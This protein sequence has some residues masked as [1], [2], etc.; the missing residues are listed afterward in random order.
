MLAGR[1][2]FRSYGSEQGLTNL[3]I[4]SLE[5]D[6]D[7]FLWVGTESGL[8]RYD[9]NRFQRFSTQDG[10]PADLVRVVYASRSGPLWLGTLQGVAVKEGNRIQALGTRS[11]LNA[12]EVFTFAEEPDG[13]IWIGADH[14][15]FRQK[16]GRLQFEP[17][18]GWPAQATARALWLDA[19]TAYVASGERV[20]VYDLPAASTP[21]EVPGPWTERVDALARDGQGRFWVRTRA[22]LWMQPAAGGA[23]LDMKGHLSGIAFFDGALRMDPSGNLLIPTAEGLARLKGETWEFI[24][25]NQGLPTPWVNRALVDREGSLWVCGTGL[26]RSLG[27]EVWRQYTQRDGIPGSV[28]QSLFLDREDRF[29]IGT[30]MGLCQA[31]PKGWT[32]V[33]ETR[34]MAVLAMLQTP[35]GALW[36]AGTTPWLLRW[37]PLNNHWQKF[38]VVE[39]TVTIL[40]RDPASGDLLLASR[41]KGLWRVFRQGSGYVVKPVSL[42]KGSLDERIQGIT[43]GTKGRVWVAGSGGLACLQDGKW[44]RYTPDEGLESLHV[45][46]VLER[47]NGD[48]WLSYL[49]SPGLFRYTLANGRLQRQ[50][51]LDTRSGLSSDLVHFLREDAR[52]RLW[53]GTSLG[54]NM[55]DGIS[56]H[57]FGTGEGLPGEDCN[58]NAFFAQANGNVWVGT[59]GGLA[60]FNAAAYHGFPAPPPTHILSA[61]FGATVQAAPFHKELSIPFRDA[62]PEF[63]F[64]GLSFLNESKVQHQIR[65]LGFEREWRNTDIRQ[66]NYTNL[67][68][69]PY[70]FEVRA[71]YGGAWGAIAALPFR[72]IPAWWQT[73]WFRTLAGL[74]I[75]GTLT[76]VVGWRLRA[77]RNKNLLLDRL[78]SERTQALGEANNTLRQLTVTDPLTGL[79]NRRYLDLTIDE[80]L[81][82][83]H[84]DHHTLAKRDVA[85]APVNIDLLFLM[86]D[87]DHFKLVNDTYGHSVGDSVLLQL[88]DRLLAAMRDTDTVVRWGGE[89]FLVVAKGTDR[90]QAGVLAERILSMIRDRP[91][92]VGGGASITKTCSL[93]FAPY[94]C[95]DCDPAGATWH[96]V[97]DV[98]DRCL[99]AAKKSGRDGWVGIQGRS[100]DQADLM[101]FL[102]D[103]AQALKNGTWD[104]ATSFPDPLELQW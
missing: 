28:V 104:L 29:W 103:P 97:V 36:L 72:I 55:I 81:A 25:E 8:F 83:V 47:A 66:A 85:R 87:L 19:K 10:L 24:G 86:V 42:P 92:D 80:D 7:G 41:R 9:G 26:H 32:L 53:A 39:S 74:A 75:L 16:P 49:T 1:L 34:G 27:R 6:R 98:A 71:G 69:G 23:F 102:E 59:L 52:G 61:K 77:L 64:A 13:R 82:K 38:P 44:V 89:E 31:G 45:M 91:F 4:W 65:L 37:D 46:A 88:R 94:P 17:L 60:T 73:W 43:G 14:G 100:A 11:G 93:G 3:S 18:P 21:R 33:P 63:R 76:A 78:V 20:L 22:Q 51:Q 57:A 58:A 56:I 95:L 67:P 70:R 12:S 62:D 96:Q 2:A 50:E 30:A 40:H 35:D 84:R 48:L 54:V 101:R 99:Y 79:K 68:P 90:S 5:Q 15:L